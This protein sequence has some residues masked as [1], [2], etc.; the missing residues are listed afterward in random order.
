MHILHMLINPFLL[1]G[2][3]FLVALHQYVN[4]GVWF[5]FKDIHHELFVVALIFGG[6][7]LLVWRS[8][9]KWV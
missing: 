4:W 2:L 5:E 9:K 8:W 6:V 7:V 1:F 3:A